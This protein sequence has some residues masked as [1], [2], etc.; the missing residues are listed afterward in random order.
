MPASLRY[1]I[2]HIENEKNRGAHR[3]QGGLI[4]VLTKELED[5][6]IGTQQD[7]LISPITLKN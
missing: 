1:Y 2:N 4:N 7:D 6:K 5:T 3:K